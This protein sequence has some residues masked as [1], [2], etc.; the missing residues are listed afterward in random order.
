[1]HK[2]GAWLIAP[3][4]LSAKSLRIPQPN[5]LN[6]TVLSKQQVA[7]AYLVRNPPACTGLK[8]QPYRVICSHLQPPGQPEPLVATVHNAVKNFHTDAMPRGRKPGWRKTARTEDRAILRA[9]F[10]VRQPCGSECTYSDVWRALD[11]ALRAKICVKTVKNR[12]MEKGYTLEDKLAADDRG[13][14]WRDRRLAFCDKHREKSEDQWGHALQAVGDYKE[15]TYFPRTLKT[16]HK[17]LNCKRTIMSKAERAKPNFAKPRHKMFSKKDYKK[18]SKAKVFGI[19]ANT[20]SSMVCPSPLHPKSKDWVKI[21]CAQVA[22]FLRGE[23]PDRQRITV[24]L[25]G[26]KVMHTEEAKAAMRRHGVRLLQQWPSHSPDLN[27]QENVWAWAQR[28]L[29]KT[30]KRRDSVATFKRRIV[31]VARRYLSSAKLVPS[32]AHRVA[33]CIKRKGANSGE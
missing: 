3:Q 4:T 22:P 24:L 11:D 12:L 26:E 31:D 10:K 16:R 29:R 13:K 5:S 19:T 1:M 18:T 6:M 15:F 33:I 7:L 23:F 30:E 21:F 14:A 32:M 2:T 17:Q 27:P 20:G 9:F 8:P 25:D 28:E